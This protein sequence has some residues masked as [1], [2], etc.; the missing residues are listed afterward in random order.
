MINKGIIRRETNTRLAIAM[1]Y[2]LVER[3]RQRY[4]RIATQNDG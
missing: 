1:H 3:T 4:E 2:T